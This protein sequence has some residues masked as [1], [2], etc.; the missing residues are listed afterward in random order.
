V[1]IGH[2]MLI[3]ACADGLRTAIDVNGNDLFISGNG[4]VASH[5]HA[6]T[7]PRNQPLSS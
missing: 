1:D 2:A 7:V 4:A 5:G 6:G 3:D